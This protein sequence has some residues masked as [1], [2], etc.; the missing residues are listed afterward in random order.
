MQEDIQDTLE[1]LNL[2]LIDMEQHNKEDNQIDIIIK[3]IGNVKK[4]E[5]KIC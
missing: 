3:A 1:D 5:I 4:E 2:E